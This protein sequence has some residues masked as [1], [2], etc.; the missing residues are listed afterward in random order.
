MM[1]KA[2]LSSVMTLFVG[3]WVASAYAADQNA[4]SSPE[5]PTAG[6][7][8]SDLGPP[9]ELTW[10]VL[11][12]TAPRL[13]GGEPGSGRKYYVNYYI[14][15]MARQAV[16]VAARDELG[17]A[18][19]DETLGDR[20]PPAV[21]APGRVHVIARG[22][23][24][25]GFEFT[26]YYNDKPFLEFKKEMKFRAT[27]DVMTYYTTMEEA[28]RN[29][30]VDALRKV[31]FQGQPNKKLASAPVPDVIETKLQRMNFVSQLA[32]VRLLHKLIREEGESPERLGAL[33]RGYS[34]LGQLASQLPTPIGK[35]FTYRAYLYAQRMVAQ[36]PESAFALWHRAYAMSLAGQ[37][38]WAIKDIK[39]ASKLAK[40]NKEKNPPWETMINNVCRFR[41]DKLEKLARQ[42]G[43]MQQLAALAWFLS[44]ENS[45][46]MALTVSTGKEA[47]EINPNCL[48]IWLALNQSAGVSYKH[49]I[50]QQAPLILIKVLTERLGDIR[51]E[52]PVIMA[53]RNRQPYEWFDG[54]TRV[55]FVR[56]LREEAGVEHDRNEPSWNA[57]AQL[58]ADTDLM[59]AF[60]RLRFLRRSLWVDADDEI[61]TFEPILASH[62][63]GPLVRAFGVP[64]DNDWA[65][66]TQKLLRDYELPRPG[67]SAGDW[68]LGSQIPN[69]Q[70]KKGTRNDLRRGM[71]YMY[72][73]YVEPEYLFRLKASMP[74]D[75]RRSSAHGMRTI[76]PH[77]P[78]R[79]ATLIETD[80]AASSKNAEKWEKQYGFHPLVAKAFADRYLE[81]G[82]RD[83]AIAHLRRYIASA[84]DYPIYIKLADLYLEKD[85]PQWLAVLE[86]FLQQEDYGL[87]HGMVN[88]K[89]AYTLMDQEK[90]EQALPYAQAAA[91]TYSGWGLTC[92]AN[93]QEAL[94]NFVEAEKLMKA[95]FERYGEAFWY[96][97]VAR[98]G[99]G[100]YEAAKKA[101]FEFLDKRYGKDRENVRAYHNLDLLITGKDQLARKQFEA[102]FERTKGAGA[103]LWVALLA[104]REG[105]VEQRDGWIKKAIEES[106]PPAESPEGSFGKRLAEFLRD[107]LAKGKVDHDALRVFFQKETPQT[108]PGLHFFCGLYYEAAG[109]KDLAK[110]HYRICAKSLYDTLPCVIYANVRLRELGEDTTKIR[111][112]YR[113]FHKD[114]W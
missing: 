88:Q 91:S 37:H 15:E 78:Q 13:D 99:K 23:P 32:A 22:I 17:L 43:D 2:I 30:I 94:G 27:R 105:D 113:K 84:A 111:R 41:F 45:G 112:E 108:R 52:P 107:G 97:W 56:D 11:K 20:I 24:E 57:L 96:C 102:D 103:A 82:D 9:E 76:S 67:V 33:V 66:E 83:K 36:Q 40:A 72:S 75:F 65:T 61:P 79:I 114:D 6:A 73:D 29:E 104:Y 53:A 19:R 21:D 42:E 59:N 5:Q 80:W 110:L 3:V 63:F 16:L 106:T 64:W 51:E 69:I 4:T 50:T 44:V 74:T 28:S 12:L 39:A 25:K 35:G 70:F 55:A 1:T 54:E 81:L 90:Y 77:S 87:S 62:P 14:Q 68:L 60:Y 100:D 46:S 31:G 34:H 85:D 101:S 71:A 93:C 8:D 38:Y 109:D 48:R 7:A 26:L 86:S 89:I 95:E 47:L 58:V 49:I 10:E 18:T 92:L 98:T